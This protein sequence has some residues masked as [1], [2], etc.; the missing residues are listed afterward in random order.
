M[1]SVGELKRKKKEG[2]GEGFA[3]LSSPATHE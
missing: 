1:S 2:R 3:T